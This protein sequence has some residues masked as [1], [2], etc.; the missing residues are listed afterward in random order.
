MAELRTAPSQ[1]RSRQTVTAI[2]NATDEVM[3]RVGVDA[4]TLTDIAEVARVSI[5]SLYR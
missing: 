2:M 3:G 5:G 1:E 4:A